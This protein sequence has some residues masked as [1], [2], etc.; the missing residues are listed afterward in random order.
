MD[1]ALLKQLDAL[2]LQRPA[3]LGRADWQRIRRRSLAELRRASAKGR[4]ITPANLRRLVQRLG[5]K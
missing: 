3:H 5:H 4:Q 2:K 1:A